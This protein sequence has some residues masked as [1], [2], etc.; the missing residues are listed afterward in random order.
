MTAGVAW[1]AGAPRLRRRHRVKQLR[2]Q[3]RDRFAPEAA[4]GVCAVIEFR[5]DTGHG[6]P[7]RFQL[8]I[9]HGSCSL[10][11]LPRRPTTTISV[12]LEDLGALLDGRVDATALFM[13]Q[14]MRVSGDLLLAARLPQFFSRWP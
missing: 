12:G 4:R 13:S 11:L 5:I 7:E 8:V 9:Q 3:L 1:S 14:R 2:Q 6:E 10:A